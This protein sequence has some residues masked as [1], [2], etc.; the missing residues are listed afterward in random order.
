MLGFILAQKISRTKMLLTCV[1][2]LIQNTLR[3]THSSSN[4]GISTV[5]K[6]KIRLFYKKKESLNIASL[7]KSICGWLPACPPASVL[8]HFE[9]D[10]KAK[11]N[12]YPWILWPEPLWLEAAMVDDCCLLDGVCLYCFHLFILD[13]YWKQTMKFISFNH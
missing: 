6:R 7:I 12:T 8:R 1:I 10:L 13:N 11:M 5:H 9:Q 2:K 4:T 3:Y